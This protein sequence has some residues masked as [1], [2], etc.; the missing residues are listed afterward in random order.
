MR[1]NRIK[2]YQ[3]VLTTLEAEV[4]GYTPQNKILNEVLNQPIEEY[5]EEFTSALSHLIDNDGLVKDLK[6]LLHK[7]LLRSQCSN[8]EDCANIS[9]L[10]VYL[11]SHY[12]KYELLT[13][14]YAIFLHMDEATYTHAYGDVSEELLILPLY[15][16]ICQNPA[17]LYD[18]MTA[19]NDL[20][21]E[22]LISR[23]NVLGHFICA[24]CSHYKGEHQLT[25]VIDRIYQHYLDHDSQMIGWLLYHM[26]NSK[27]MGYRGRVQHAYEMG[28]VDKEIHGDTPHAFI[29]QEASIL[30]YSGIDMSD[31][32]DLSEFCQMYTAVMIRVHQER[33]SKLVKKPSRTLFKALR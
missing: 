32:N 7:G 13:Y 25:S 10:F 28:I 9:I 4:S 1:F 20:N 2:S 17:G 6:W 3:T 5:T 30:P 12:K 31:H 29:Q 11:I 14:W 16:I 24:V 22:T 26:R 19:T 18:I 21:P 33:R 15:Q 27:I 8:G 23:K